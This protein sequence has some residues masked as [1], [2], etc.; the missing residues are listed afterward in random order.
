M[1]I[2][3]HGTADEISLVAARP[4][5]VLL[6]A[7]DLPR[8]RVFELYRSHIAKAHPDLERYRLCAVMTETTDEGRTV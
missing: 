1:K 5:M 7:H 3:F 6:T 2:C 4:L 8:M